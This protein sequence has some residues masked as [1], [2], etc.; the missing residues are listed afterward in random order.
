LVENRTALANLI[1]GLAAEYGVVFPLSIKALRSHLPLALE[2]TENDLSPIMR[3]L[4]H[5]LYC[6]FVSLSEEID[7]IPHSVTILSQKNPRYEAIRNISGFGPILTLVLIS[8]VGAGNQFQNGRQFSAWCS[9]PPKQN[10][11]G[12][13]SSLG[14]L[15]KNG[16]RELRALLI[17][18]ARA[19]VR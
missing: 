3:N 1:R 2:D 10:S 17:H 14:S 6:D 11:T 19:V 8:E 15:P 16:N 4:L 7:E 12:G 9:L 13:K 18:S 5:T